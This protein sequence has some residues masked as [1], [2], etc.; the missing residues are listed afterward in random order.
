[1]GKNPHVISRGYK[2]SVQTV[3]QVDAVRHSAD[4]VGDEPLLIAKQ[5]P[6]WVAP[7]R[8][9]AAL[10]AVS[11][12]ADVIVMDDGMQNPTIRKR[13][14]I[15][16]V[17]GPYGFGNR[18][19]L[20]A[21]PCREPISVSLEKADALVI[22]GTPVHDDVASIA[23]LTDYQFYAQV[24]L[25]DSAILPDRP[26]IAF[27]GIGRPQK[28]FAFADSLGIQTLRRYAFADHH[29]FTN[30][31]LEKLRREAEEQRALLLTT[32]KD[33][34]RLPPDWQ[35]CVSY[36]P[37]ALEIQDETLFNQLLSQAVG[38]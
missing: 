20:P 23:P 18:Q 27:A 32:E 3:L 31:Q 2:G 35:A 11:A 10:A 15:M 4:E 16:V 17:D 5:Y 36:L 19:M 34:V 38:S 14:T 8:I 7:K 29:R 12:G 13:Y 26:V 24:R 33:W 1:M 6:C 30:A 25:A 28:F 21:G 22:I 9:D 37:I